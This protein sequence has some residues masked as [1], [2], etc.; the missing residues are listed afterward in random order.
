MRYALEHMQLDPAYRT[1]ITYD[2]FEAGHMMYDNLPDLKKLH[3]V[4]EKFLT[5]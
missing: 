2:T 1:N 5:K 4:L 3:T